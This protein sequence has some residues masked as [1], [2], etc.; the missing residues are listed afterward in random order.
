MAIAMKPKCL[1]RIRMANEI[2]PCF[3]CNPGGKRSKTIVLCAY[4]EFLHMA[5]AIC[6]L[7]V[8]PDG[9]RNKTNVL[10]RIRA[11]PHSK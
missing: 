6:F 3:V 9:K 8:Y 10:L 4:P 1:F 7:F 2:K 5:N 11:Y